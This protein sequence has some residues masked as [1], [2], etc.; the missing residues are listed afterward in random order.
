MTSALEGLPSAF[1]GLLPGLDALPLPDEVRADCAACPMLEAAGP[2]VFHADARCCTFHPD[3]PNFLVGRLLRQGGTSARAVLRRLQLSDGVSLGGI[4]PSEAYSARYAEDRAHGFGKDVHLRCPYWVGGDLACGV[5]SDRGAVCRTWFC[6]HVDGPRGHRLWLRARKALTLVEHRLARWCLDQAQGRPV[7]TTTREWVAWF[8]ACAELVD[9]V[10]ASR[11]TTP[12]IEDAWARVREV[13]G[14]LARPDDLPDVL[15]PTVRLR[16]RDGDLVWL[17]GYSP[18]DGIVVPFGVFGF[19]S[20][21]DGGGTWQDRAGGLPRHRADL[22]RRGARARA[23]PGGR[24]QRRG[25][26]VESRRA[27]SDVAALKPP[28]HGTHRQTASTSPGPR[29]PP[30]ARRPGRWQGR[31]RRRRAQDDHRARHP[32]AHQGEVRPGSP[33]ARQAGSRGPRRGDGRPRRQGARSHRGALPCPRRGPDDPPARRASTPPRSRCSPSSAGSACSRCSASAS[34]TCVAP[35]RRSTTAT[36]CLRCCAPATPW[37]CTTCTSWR[38]TS[39]RARARREERSA[40][41]SSSSTPSATEAIA[42]LREAGCAIWV[43][44]LA[45]D[46]VT[47]EQL[48]LDR[49]VCLWFGAEL[50]GVT[51]EARARRRSAWSP[52]RC[53]GSPSR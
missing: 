48:P 6:L 46:S 20:L 45:D 38:A 53:E 26:L 28:A 24:D 18:F 25:G 30:Q 9:R 10:D 44:D 2:R 12:E 17:A 35:S 3:L 8:W 22:G 50:V 5:W 4:S 16:R 49:P 40:G 36:T 19:L 39:R 32:R 29:P 47:P 51:P 33:G 7:P 21:L 52:C 34:A 41:S 15:L 14:P 42:A 13:A 1:Y 37:A 23:V 31:H 27:R 43:A 11:L